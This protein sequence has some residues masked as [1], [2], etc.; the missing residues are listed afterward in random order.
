[1]S[2]RSMHE[3]L[4]DQTDRTDDIMDDEISLLDLA[5]VLARHKKSIILIPL[6]SGI[7]AFGLTF[8]IPAT[9]TAETKILPPQQ[10]SSTVALLANQLGALGGMAGTSLGLKNPNDLY[11]GMLKSRTVSD[12]LIRQFQLQRVY[13]KKTLFDTRKKLAKASSVVS[14]KDGIITVSVED[15]DPQR[16]AFLANAYITELQKLTEVLAVTEASQRR[17]FYEKQLYQVRQQLSDAEIAMKQTQEK[18]GLIQL[19]AQAAA[20]VQS[21]AALRSQ[22]AMKEVQLNAMR[23]FATSGNPDYVRVQ[24]EIAGLRSQL[25]RVET[26]SVTPSKAPEAGLEY[27]R[28]LRDL[29]YYETLYELLAKQFEMAKLDEAKESSLIQVLDKAI[30]PEKKSKPKRGLIAVLVVFAAGFG[31]VLRAFIV[32]GLSRAKEDDGNAARF[33]MLRQQLKW[34]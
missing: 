2:A 11:V 30:V 7:F 15:H 1:M 28:K 5:I 25:S 17:L 12:N 6:I 26:G 8:A 23:T 9:F 4:P 33:A 32:E 3:Q 19:D 13:S 14:G 16:A 10:Q 18:T 34:K 24:Q 21:V 22:M 27:I 20:L 29:K 31:A